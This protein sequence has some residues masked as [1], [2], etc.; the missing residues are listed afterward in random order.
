MNIAV[1]LSALEFCFNDSCLLLTTLSVLRS[2]EIIFFLAAQN[3]ERWRKYF[4]DGL[5]SILFSF[6]Y[7][8]GAAFIRDKKN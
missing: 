2:V 5:G 1:K 8:T 7:K 4:C 6:M 3:S